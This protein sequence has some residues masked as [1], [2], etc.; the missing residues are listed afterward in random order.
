[1]DMKV[2]PNHQFNR[3][4]GLRSLFRSLLVVPLCLLLAG[5]GAHPSALEFRSKE[6]LTNH[7][8]DVLAEAVYH[9]EDDALSVPAL[10][11]LDE[12][13]P[14]PVPNPKKFG[15]SSDPSS[16]Q[17][18]LDDAAEILD[19]QDTLFSTD[20]ELVPNS[21]LTYYLD[22]S[23]F[24][25]TWKQ[26][27]ARST[28]TISEIKITDPS[29]FR[30]YI[31]DNDI[32]G[33]RL[34][35]PT[36]MY[37]MVNAVVGSSADHYRARRRGVIVYEGEVIRVDAPHKIDTCYID[38]NGDLLFTYRGDLTGVEDAQAFVDKNNIRFSMAFGPVLIDNGVRCEP[39]SYSLGEVN[40]HY[41]RAALCQL[42]DL[43]YLV[44]TANAEGRYMHS[45]TIHEFAEV[46]ESF[47][48]QKA[49]ALDGGNTGSIVMN[50]KLINRLPFNYERA[51]GDFIYF[52]TAIPNQ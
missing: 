30:R 33:T 4:P 12:H 50:G 36:T 9:A 21:K 34:Y 6:E 47:G 26:G 5:V 52:S 23:I 31:A 49:Y 32:N 46:I 13:I 3:T 40:D 43:H 28:Y 25:V 7:I 48:C 18:L 35:I 51:Q 20:V 8:H 27:T 42:G 2:T 17:W 1:M 22:N 38:K 19:G 29:Q 14:A 39:A 15:S 37:K 10:F 16:L 41:A 44:V 24:A 11:I 45:P